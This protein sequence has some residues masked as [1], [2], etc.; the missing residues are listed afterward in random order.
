MLDRVRLLAGNLLRELLQALCLALSGVDLLAKGRL[1]LLHIEHLR[2]GGAFVRSLDRL[3]ELVGLKVEVVDAAKVVLDLVLQGLLRLKRCLE[4][5][6][7]CLAGGLD[8]LHAGCK[9]FHLLENLL[10]PS[11]ALHCAGLGRERAQ[12]VQHRGVERVAVFERRVHLEVGFHLGDGGPGLGR[13]EERHLLVEPG[14][15]RG[16]LGVELG[17]GMVG[18]LKRQEFVEHLAFIAL[19][20]LLQLIPGAHDLFEAHLRHKLGPVVV[21]L[22]RDQRGVDSLR[23][24]ALRSQRGLGLF[25]VL[26]ERIKRFLDLGR[27][28]QRLLLFQPPA[29]ALRLLEHLLRDRLVLRRPLVVAASYLHCVIHCLELA[30]KLGLRR[31][32]L[33]ELRQVGDL[34][35][36]VRAV[37]HV[38]GVEQPR[39]AQVLLCD[40]EG[41]VAVGQRLHGLQRVKVL[42]EIRAVA[43]DEGVEGEPVLPRGGEIFHL[44]AG[45]AFGGSLQPEQQARLAVGAGHLEAQDDGP[46]QTEHELLVALENI[47]RADVDEWNVVLLDEVEAL[48]EVLELLDVHAR[49]LV[50]AAHSLA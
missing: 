47:R 27:R 15:H 9:L 31:E 44:H 8:F 28:G 41:R 21:A 16:A 30:V 5:L 1:A 39:D 34:G 33:E 10:P 25:H 14:A 42:D 50:D 45:V 32:E 3:L 37:D 19:L 43:V 18:H 38:L 29:L 7:V 17:H 12:I 11:V 2:R 4:L 49:V 36:F 26:V 46:Q 24:G 40:G 22:A 20:V 48:V 6:P 13:R 23:F 35:L